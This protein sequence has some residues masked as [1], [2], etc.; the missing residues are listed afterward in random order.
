MSLDN[1]LRSSLRDIEIQNHFS[2]REYPRE[3]QK[4]LDN[5]ISRG[6]ILGPSASPPHQD[7]H[8]SPL[9][10]RPK[11]SN[12]RKV[13]LD[14]SYPKG[15]SLND[16]VNR[17]SYDGIAYKL[18]FPTTDHICEAISQYK[19]PYISKIDISRT[20]CNLELIQLML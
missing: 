16:L 18:K 9:L 14:L 13:V 8:C 3:V 17:D 15:K 10:T 19:D 6:A 12:D 2:S 4:F 5:E 11:D 7:M 1:Q 20:V